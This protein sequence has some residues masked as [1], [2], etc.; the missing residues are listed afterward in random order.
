MSNSDKSSTAVVGTGE[1]WE[2]DP[3]VHVDE[4]GAMALLRIALERDGGIDVIERL[5]ALREREQ[6]REAER[7]FDAAMATFR[8]QVPPI[9]RDRRGAGF[10]PKGGG[11]I[12]YVMY[13]PL[14][15]IQRV[16]DP[17]LSAV[18]LRYWWSS[19]ATAD[20]VTT[21]CH[22][23]HVGGF[24][25]RSTMT[26]PVTGPPKSSA[27]QAHGGTRSFAKRLTLSDV[28]GITTTDDV[29][30]ADGARTDPL[31]DDQV[32]V[33]S[34]H[35]DAIREDGIRF[36]IVRFCRIFDAERIADIAADRYEE[37]LG[38]LQTRLKS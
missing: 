3:T 37:A 6:E 25:Q 36:D 18:G 1:P 4:P 9:P 20:T 16:C 10:A 31:S 7:A 13:A 28:L 29:D 32:V 27:T 5:S 15:T 12:H 17:L 35:V 34:E 30:G 24:G 2:V 38:L 33:L 23:R 21:T 26:L 14:E 8:A 19:E 11:A 22:L